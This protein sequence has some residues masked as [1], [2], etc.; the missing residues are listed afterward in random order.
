MERYL[1]NVIL[2]EDEDLARKA[3]V[4]GLTNIPGSTLEGAPLF[5][6][7]VAEAPTLDA[8]FR[9]LRKGK[10]A[11]FLDNKPFL[12][13]DIRFLTE[14]SSHTLP[15]GL[16]VLLTIK[17]AEYKGVVLFS[18]MQRLLEKTDISIDNNPNVPIWALTKPDD[19]D[20]Y[21]P[22]LKNFLDKIIMYLNKAGEGY[23]SSICGA[24]DIESWKGAVGSMKE[25]IDRLDEETR[26]AICPR[27]INKL[28]IT[29]IFR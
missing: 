21:G 3:I 1:E 6:Q 2:V 29:S 13:L 8:Y 4:S 14:P 20:S 12:I 16:D 26:A 18:S 27:N 15:S 23:L 17:P 5:Y 22:R 11:P 28:G 10:E 24:K 19:M 7:V 9:E 25:Y